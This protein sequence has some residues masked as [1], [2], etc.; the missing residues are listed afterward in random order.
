MS[1]REFTEKTLAL[2]VVRRLEFNPIGGEP[3]SKP[4]GLS[5]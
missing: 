5:I 4:D 1:Q 3:Q 2:S